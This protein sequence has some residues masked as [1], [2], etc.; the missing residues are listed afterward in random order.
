MSQCEQDAL[1]AAHFV[2][3]HT[4]VWFAVRMVAAGW[5]YKQLRWLYRFT[6]RHSATAQRAWT[7][8]SKYFLDFMGINTCKRLNWYLFCSKIVQ[9]RIIKQILHLCKHDQFSSEHLFIWLSSVQMIHIMC[10]LCSL[11][12]ALFASHWLSIH[13]VIT[14]FYCQYLNN[15]FCH[16]P[17][18]GRITISTSNIWGSSWRMGLA[19]VRDQKMVSIY[20]S[21]PSEL[22][23]SEAKLILSAHSSHIL[24]SIIYSK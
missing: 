8:C 20:Q 24:H 9:T 3:L 18:Q 14:I 1:S 17:V 10:P 5:W 7:H 21:W 6:C 4:S 2:L 16:L 11:V 22:G 15:Y 23:D 19:I 13:H 12:V